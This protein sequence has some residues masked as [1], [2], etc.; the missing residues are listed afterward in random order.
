M[1]RRDGR[2]PLGRVRRMM[3]LA[4]VAA[5]AVGEWAVT[6]LLA[7]AG[8]IDAVD[9]FRERNAE[10]YVRY[11]GDCRGL[12]MKAGQILS[13]VDARAWG[14]GAFLPY[15]QALSRMQSEVPAMS[16][17]LV[18]ELLEAELGAGVELFAD[19]V[20]EP[21][22]TASIG[23]VHRAVLH[24]GRQVAVKI[25]YPGVDQA[26][27]ED[28]ANAELLVAFLR[29]AATM[30]G[31]KVDI[32]GLARELA[33]R[34]HEELDYRHEAATI[35][36]FSELY[37][38]HPF[39]RIPQVVSEVSSDRILTMTYLDGM[40]WARAQHAD[41]DLK[42]TWAEAIMRFVYGNPRL[43]NL[44]HADPYPENY[45]F[46]NDGTVGFLD[47]GCVQ[48]LADGD[49][50]TWAAMIR[51]ALE[52][53]KTDLRLL[54]AQAGFLD[55]DP[56]LSADELYQWWEDLIREFIVEPQPVTYTPQA[57][58]RVIRNLL[59]IRDRSHPIARVRVPQ[60][61]A[62]STRIQLN[63]VSIL[64]TMGATVPARAIADDIDYVSEPTTELGKQHHAWIHARDLRNPLRPN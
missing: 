11:L 28:L 42:N 62:F 44:L 4:G 35:T 10:N 8:K 1:Q 36:S 3:P 47:F 25:Q 39:I 29:F 40:D 6:G 51:A 32:R 63:L 41:Q 34:I 13:M 30:A 45:R 52:G 57:T 23:Q 19:L 2:V 15:Q 58:G 46:N 16:S 22:A 61:H 24:D 20:E 43:A 33:A 38:G 14:E 60:T 50:R 18:S 56:T 9:R 55:A 48:V 21:I 31:I 53:R 26:I 49:R 27:R 59:D 64:A 7:R 54:M 5:G 12:L 17:G 37:R